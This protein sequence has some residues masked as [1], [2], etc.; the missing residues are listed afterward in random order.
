[1]VFENRDL[2]L[3]PDQLG[4]TAPATQ[5]TYRVVVPA[6]T[7]KDINNNPINAIVDGDYQVAVIAAR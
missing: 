5:K 7:V 4:V 6:A 2:I 1:M 3:K